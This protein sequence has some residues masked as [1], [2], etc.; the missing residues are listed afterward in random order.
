MGAAGR[1]FVAAECSVDPQ[2]AR[3]LALVDAAV[4]RKPL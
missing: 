2:A 1:A 4:S 3:L